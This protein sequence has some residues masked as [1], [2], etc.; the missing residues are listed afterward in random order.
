MS[1]AYDYHLNQKLHNY[2]RKHFGQL[3]KK[4]LKIYM[5]LYELEAKG[6]GFCKPITASYQTLSDYSYV[7][8]NNIKKALSELNGSLCEVVI[9]SPIYRNKQATQIRRYSIDELKNN[10]KHVLRTSYPHVANQLAELLMKKPIKYGDEILSP[11][12]NITRTGR[13]QSSRPNIQGD[14][15]ERRRKQLLSAYG[16]IIDIDIKA[17]EPTL[18]KYICGYK[19]EGCLYDKYTKLTGETRDV[20]K[21]KV[22]MIAY[23][24]NSRRVVDHWDDYLQP[25]FYQYADALDQYKDQLWKKGT[26]RAG[27]R[28]FIYTLNN[29]RIE[30]RIREG[31]HKGQVFCWQV[32]GTIAD[33]INKI[34]IEIINRGYDY[35]FP[36][37]DGFYVCGGRGEKEDIDNIVSLI[38][39]SMKLPLTFNSLC[40]E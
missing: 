24:K 3:D 2:A 21:A 17:A 12:W 32:Q 16:S 6:L 36:M 22:N 40:L 27:K 39:Q 7:H 20:A 38:I 15:A 29:T 37:H 30:S 5:S 9:G 23:A 1:E 33:L 35:L 18:V 28:R 26:P 14:S 31:T 34:S 8:R 19:R 13:M 11:D 25:I 4:S 10:P